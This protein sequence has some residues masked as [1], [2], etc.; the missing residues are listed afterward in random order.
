[1]RVLIGKVTGH[2]PPSDASTLTGPAGL[3]KEP[4][5]GPVLVVGIALLLGLAMAKA[6]TFHSFCFDPIAFSGFTWHLF[7]MLLHSIKP[8]SPWPSVV[9]PRHPQLGRWGWD[10]FGRD[11]WHCI[12]GLC[13]LD[14]CPGTLGHMPYAIV[15]RPW[16]VG[17]WNEGVLSSISWCVIL[18]TSSGTWIPLILEYSN[19]ALPKKV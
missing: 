8:C 13:S 1:M 9:D 10:N 4:T 16:N 2:S 3:C 15:F 7:F 6:G 17:G 12:V 19:L 11:L 18:F 5:L 14:L